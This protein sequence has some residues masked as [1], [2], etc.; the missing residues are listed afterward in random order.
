MP[1]TV[2]FGYYCTL[3]SFK[4][5]CFVADSGSDVTHLQ[6]SV[7]GLERIVVSKAYGL[8]LGAREHPSS[9]VLDRGSKHRTHGTGATVS[10]RMAQSRCG[11]AGGLLAWRPD[12][13]GHEASGLMGVNRGVT[14]GLWQGSAACTYNENSDAIL[15]ST[16][17]KK[18]AKM[19]L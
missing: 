6:S 5:G 10:S 19:A 15:E 9:A 8:Y 3:L 13:V 7:P 4:V 18:D 1:V 2:A 16:S 17:K 11:S 14:P 12:R